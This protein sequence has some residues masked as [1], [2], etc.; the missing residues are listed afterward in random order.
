MGFRLANHRSC[1]MGEELGVE[2][3]DES[4]RADLVTAPAFTASMA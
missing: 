2:G 4:K 3:P 1:G